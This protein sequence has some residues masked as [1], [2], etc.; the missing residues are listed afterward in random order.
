M[1]IP[2]LHGIFADGWK[3]PGA[4]PGARCSDFGAPPPEGGLFV[5]N[6]PAFAGTEFWHGSFI[7]VPG[8]GDQEMLRRV[9]P[10]TQAP[11]SAWSTY[12][13]VTRDNWQF[14]CI[15]TMANGGGEGF[16][17]LAPDG[18]TY[19]FDWMVSRAAPRLRKTHGFPDTGALRT[20]EAE[21][22]EQAVKGGPA[23][24]SDPQPD[25]IPID[26][27][28]ISRSEVW[29]L[30]TLITDR[31]GNTVTYTYDTTNKWQLK[32]ITGSEASGVQRELTLEYV[33]PS[34]RLVSTVSDGTR[35]WR[36]NYNDTTVGAELVSVTLPDNS[37][38]Q[39]DGLLPLFAKDIEYG[40]EGGCEEPG[41]LASLPVSGYLV[42][43]S[44]ARGDFTLS[45]TRHGR[46]GVAY[47]CP[48]TADMPRN[49]KYFKLFDTYALTRKVLSGPGIAALEWNT[50][51]PAAEASW[52]PCSGCVA[53]KTVEVTDPSGART[54]HTFGTLFR[55][56]EGQLQE[57]EVVD[58]S[59]TVLRT[60]S[61]EYRRFADRG[62][63]DQGR[64]DGVLAARVTKVNKRVT[65]QQGASFTWEASAFDAF[66]NPTQVARSSSLGYQRHET[67]TYENNTTNWV[68][69]Q[70]KEV[71]DTVSGKVMVS[72]VYHPGTAT[73]SSVT[74]F[75]S[76]QR[77]ML[78]H[79]DGTIS[80]VED[81][82]GQATTYSTYKR[83]VPQ[84]ITYPAES[85]QSAASQSA[86]VNNIGK[87][88]SL[89][90][91]NGY[92]TRFEYD[93]AGR[94]KKITYPSADS[95]VWNVTAI[96]VAPSSGSAFG[97]PA[98]HWRQQVQTG[99][100]YATT[101]YDA[102]LRPAWE[103]RYDGANRAATTRIVKYEHDF[104]GR[105]TFESYPKRSEGE[106]GSG[107][108]TS[109][110]A[111]GRVSGIRTPGDDN[112]DLYT[113]YAYG[114]GFT[115]TV[116]D[117]RNNATTYGYQAFDEP[118]DTAIASIS[119]PEGVSV[120]IARDV[121]GKPN[122]I[123]RTGNDRSGNSV[124]VT[125]SYVYDGNERLCKTIEPETGATLQDYDGAGNVTWR[126]SGTN[127]SKIA[128]CDRA[129]VLAGRKAVHTYD[130]RNRLTRTAFGD[131]SPAIDRTYTPDGLPATVKSGKSTWTYGY[132]KR[133]LLELESLVYGATTY[134][135][136][137]TYDANGSL[138]SLKYPGDA[139]TVA[140]NPNALG[141]PQQVGSYATSI[142]YHPNGAIA[143]FKYGNGIVRTMTQNA[144]GLPQTAV[145]VGVLSDKYTYD[146]N[147]NVLGIEDVAGGA[148][149]R[150]MTYD[151]LDRLKTASAPN[152]W[153]LATYE[154]DGQDNLVASTIT[155]GANARSAT[156]AID[157]L[158]NRLA[159]VTAS[160]ASFTFAYDYDVQGNIIRRGSRNYV[161][162]VANRMS[163][164]TSLATYEYDGH[165]RRVSVVGTDGVNRI[166][167]YSQD[168]KLLYTTAGT[169]S[170]TKYIY[171]HNHAIAEVK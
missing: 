90:D 26:M 23:L 113:T 83:G 44:G 85:G 40:G 55:E 161:F 92:T 136:R 76:L 12:P 100:A 152:L 20:G 170:A 103:E 121:F 128:A 13:V 39:L 114:E 102:L 157:S 153:G 158:T 166:Q 31:F 56:T 133:R 3:S 80:S 30:P 165:G 89:T 163:S 79:T 16:L 10:N 65:T 139:T 134:D 33:S 95:V 117:P 68:L 53:A 75:G 160:N 21:Q 14:K 91:E 149:T 77:K 88:D 164:A 155:G 137:R 48:Q 81:G 112:T 67:S 37:Q 142:T 4:V 111:L 73:L 141:E 145:D 59:G 135:I 5:N 107:K 169:G 108:H 78:Y 51:Y 106:T 61:L 58:V 118:V 143:G 19:R 34:S 71:K 171:L 105:A 120:A 46:A 159:S 57:T 116:T 24:P 123:Q 138:S 49:A 54:R 130:K 97:L 28:M 129:T 22:A 70:L 7:Y 140:Y 18:T 150:S 1:E 60:T 124:T 162:D 42:H 62:E 52:G 109:Y 168:G 15:T 144:R 64:G 122:S 154:Y 98:G 104:N 17:A 132:N 131:A 47:E 38:W 110:D 86:V 94:L 41:A 11:G 6:Q 148:T 167:V 82:K 115:T 125:R 127:L 43:P 9:G 119:L 45:P 2:H 8:R 147:G 32:K 50:A 126:A 63:S 25:S 74:R 96:D 29:I 84:S 156:H 101:H 87:L 27:T 69:G 72:N 93:A 99:N 146:E 66:A 35:I 151:G 36:Y